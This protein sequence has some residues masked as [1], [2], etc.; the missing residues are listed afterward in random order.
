MLWN[1]EPIRA[2]RAT[3]SRRIDRASPRGDRMSGTPILTLLQ[4]MTPFPHFIDALATLEE[5]EETMARHGIRHL[6][7]KS[8]GEIVG[9]IDDNA[10]RLA[11]ER[12]IE[13]PLDTIACREVYLAQVHTPLS[14]VCRDLAERRL[15]TALVLRG[16]QL[17]GIFTTTDALKALADLLD[18]PPVPDVPA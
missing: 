12:A 10:M 4:V 7:V 1:R 3:W 6:P 13:G 15:D 5:V 11:R 2:A 9:V 8:N 14:I 18:P 17:A 16:G